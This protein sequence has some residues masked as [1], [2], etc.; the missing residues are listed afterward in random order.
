MKTIVK[1][2]PEKEYN[3]AKLSLVEIESRLG[4][5]DSLSSVDKSLDNLNTVINVLKERLGPKKRKKPPKKTNRD[6]VRK[7]KRENEEK[8]KLPSEKFPDLNIEEKI[9]RDEH[10]PYCECCNA[11]MSE[12]GLYKTSEKLEVIPKQYYIIRKQRVIYNCSNCHGSMRN[13]RPQP[14]IIPKSN[15]GD[16]LVIDIALSKYA[17]LIPIERQSAII[18]REGLINLPANSMIDATHALAKFLKVI[19][20]KLKLEVLK[21]LILR[22]DETTHKMLEGDTT[23]NWFLWGFFCETA[24]YF[25]AH[26][27]RSGDVPLEFLKLSEAL[28]LITD[29]YSGYQKAIDLLKKE[30]DR[31]VIPVFCN[32]HAFR[33]FESASVTWESEAEP[34]LNLYGE[35]YKLERQAENEK[36]KKN[37]RENMLP[38]FEEMLAECKSIEESLMPH[39]SISKAV[40][41]FLNHY[42][43]LTECTKNISLDLDNNSSERS[44][45][46]P[47]VGRKTWYGTHS[48]RGA[49]TNVI[50]FSIVESCKINGTNPRRYFPDMVNDIHNGKEPL[51]PSEYAKLD[52]G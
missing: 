47:V 6:L 34:F 25:E 12:S 9:V 43:G 5:D 46:S 13:A 2:D 33:Y 14:S 7:R 37:A 39:S 27:T 21:S 19:Y 32:A 3:S 44:L 50:L 26:G 36:D 40:C 28:Y 29:G 42:E 17:D 8:N 30:Q 23:R 31:T 48:T 41:Y 15:Y 18:G 10:P 16:S 51:T 4:K 35:I 38:L 49:S 24:C 45:R 22:C 11:Q 1:I 52:S 20:K